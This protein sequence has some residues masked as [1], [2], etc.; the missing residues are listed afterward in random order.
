MSRKIIF[1]GNLRRIIPVF[2]IFLCISGANAGNQKISNS[3][4]PPTNHGSELLENLRS[5]FGTGTIASQIRL[6]H[7]LSQYWESNP[8]SAEELTS[9]ISDTK[10][11]EAFRIYL[12]KVLRNKIKKQS[13]S[14]EATSNT[15]SKMRDII[16]N[17]ANRPDFRAK[18]ANVLTTVDQSDE[19]VRAV[20]P[21][22]LLDDESAAK[23]VSALCN[24]TNP[25]A[26][27]T[28][29]DFVTSSQDLMK[30]KPRALMAALPPLSTT[31]KDV[32]P[33]VNR[34]VNTTK[35][36]DLYRSAIQALIHS[37]SSPAV[38]ESIAKAFDV[39]PRFGKR[40]AQAELLSKAAARQHVQLFRG[41]KNE[42]DTNTT[43]TIEK[44]VG[45]NKAK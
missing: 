20:T 26:V 40:Q 23:A 38:L 36:F 25:L 41:I 4:T 44:L 43:E 16:A 24:T 22:L 13:F 10:A 35:N 27:D 1:K 45:P 33:V 9:L 8:P 6:Q 7:Q 39:A 2:F 21:L 18:L 5:S 31:D 30:T 3:S 14:T 17:A 29:Y 15:Y 42:L 32:L 12:A 11:P 37:K 28:L 19:T 34:V